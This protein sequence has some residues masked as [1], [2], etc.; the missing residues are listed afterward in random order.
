MPSCCP[1]RGNAGFSLVEVLFA[2]AIVGLALG[3]AASVFRNGILG[4]QAAS[5]VDTALALAEEQLAAAGVAEPLR[6]GDRQG[7]FADRFAWH[8]AV[9]PD[10]DA[11][12]APPSFKLYRLSATVAWRDGMRQREI[13]LETLRL[14][15]ASP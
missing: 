6:E 10:P 4:H 11:G 2:L 3:T 12:A 9:A 13:A 15:P 5:D 14:A 1:D 8:L 7:V